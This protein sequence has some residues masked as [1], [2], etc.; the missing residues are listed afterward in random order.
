MTEGQTNLAT[1]ARA[2]RDAYAEWTSSGEDAAYE[3]FIR[4]SNAIADASRALDAEAPPAIDA[5]L[6]DHFAGQAL[7]A[8]GTWSPSPPTGESINWLDAAPV[9]RLRAQYAYEVADAMLKERAK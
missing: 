3:R 1:A 4:A 2:W 6:R 5:T 7:I 8:M 9:C